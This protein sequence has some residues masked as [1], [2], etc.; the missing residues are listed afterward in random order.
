MNRENMLIEPE[1]L[2]K[3]LGDIN[4]RIFDASIGDDQYRQGHIPG[5]AFFDHDKFSD[6][7]GKYPGTVLPEAELAMQI[8]DIGIS[9][10][11]EVVFYAWG[12]LPY[13]ARAWWLL[14]YAGHENVRVL[15]GGLAAWKDAG[16]SLEKEARCYRPSTFVGHF[17]PNRFADKQ[18][19]LEAMND[20]EVSTEDVL[21]LESYEA[22]HITG[23]TCLPCLDLMQ[24]LD[25]F[26]PAGQIARRLEEAPQAKRVI[27]YCGGGI[28]AAVNAM[29]YLMIGQENVAVYDGSLNE[30]VGE[31]L[32]TTGE[33]KWAIWEKN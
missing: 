15:N 28:A 12:M 30:W 21:P 29:A 2:L 5:A 18:A 31:R 23:S 13:A 11:I 14:H 17:K 1:E 8:G 6:P 9:N 26:L 27:T 24:G 7:N 25:A 3:K 22:A 20:A 19:V 33:G 32:P 16:G 4:I 10:D